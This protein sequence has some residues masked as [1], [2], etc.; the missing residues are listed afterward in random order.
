MRKCSTFQILFL[1]LFVGIFCTDV[2]A[3]EKYWVSFTDKPL[4]EY[5][6]KDL[7]SE[8]A[9]QRRIRNHIP[10]LQFSDLPVNDQ[11]IK[12]VSKVVDGTRHVSKWLNGMSVYA[13]LD[14]LAQLQEFPWVSQVEL[15]SPTAVQLA[16]FSA[17]SAFLS[18]HHQAILSAQTEIMGGS[19]LR[20]KQ[21]DGEGVLIAV[22]DVG[23]RGTDQRPEF[24]HL[25]ESN[26]V[27]AAYDFIQN[28]DNVYGSGTHGT[29][30]LSCIAGLTN[31]SP[32]GLA[33]GAT[34]ILARTERNLWETMGEEDSWLAATEWADSLGADVI[35]SSLG[36]TYNRYFWKDLDGQQALVSRAAQMAF[37]KGIVV[38]NAAG[39]DGDGDWEYIGAPADAPGVLSVGGVSPWSGY[40]TSFSAFGPTADGRLKPNVSAFGHVIAC[41]PK[42]LHQTSGTSFASPLVC[43]FVACLLQM[44]PEYTAQEAFDAVQ[45]SGHLYPY[46]DY[47]HGYGIP[48]ASSLLEQTDR[49][50]V[51][52][53][54][55]WNAGEPAAFIELLEPVEAAGSN[56]GYTYDSLKDLVYWHAAKAD[57][58]IVHYGVIKPEGQRGGILPKSKLDGASVIRIHYKGQTELYEI[59]P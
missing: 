8:R 25:F 7:L 20:E 15:L 2:G 55:N 9:I 46:Y 14:Q 21:V 56:T 35:N 38:V 44:Y 10:L 27:L 32:M 42:G 28:D 50:S 41:G 13:T 24:Q 40:A 4:K 47:V 29:N 57:G 12:E 26:R 17:D 3:Q 16:G 19:K 34:F 30:V 49:D 37:E 31:D 53:E 36:Y 59:D 45:S 5:A 43:G 51:S 54:F 22:F 18:S 58:S 11:Y 48:Q 1:T 33:T 6:P 39:N 23:F 52:F